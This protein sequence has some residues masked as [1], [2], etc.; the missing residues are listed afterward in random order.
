MARLMRHVPVMAST[1]WILL[2]KLTGTTS[3][4]AQWCALLLTAVCFFKNEKTVQLIQIRD[5]LIGMVFKK[6]RLCV[7]VTQ[8]RMD[9]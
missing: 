6:N 4:Q 7:N 5:Q 8:H 1:G 3:V 2:A 9:S